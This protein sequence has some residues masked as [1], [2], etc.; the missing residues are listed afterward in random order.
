MCGVYSMPYV[1]SSANTVAISGLLEHGVPQM[2]IEDGIQNEL[3]H[4]EALI[5]FSS[6]FRKGYQTLKKNLGSHFR[7]KKK[8]YR[9]SPA[10]RAPKENSARSCRIAY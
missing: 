7:K 6:R 3:V 10:W 4:F 1:K 5:L 8:S 9:S 2:R